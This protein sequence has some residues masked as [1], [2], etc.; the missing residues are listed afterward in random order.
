MVLQFSDSTVLQI[1]D[2]TY[3]KGVAVNKLSEEI[4]FGL[5]DAPSFKLPK[6]VNT[7]WSPF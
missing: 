4:I 1:D 6:P 2:L 7:I 5:M 3:Y